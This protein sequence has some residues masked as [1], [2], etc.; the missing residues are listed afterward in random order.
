MTHEQT[1]HDPAVYQM[2]TGYRHVSTAGGLKVE[3]DDVPHMAAALQRV[4]GSPTVMPKAIETPETMQMNGRV[5]PG[6]SGGFLGTSYDPLRVEVTSDLQV[7][8]PEF[9]LVAE[10]DPARF[11][12]REQLLS[13]DQ[14]GLARLEATDVVRRY[15]GLRRQALEILRAGQVS[16]AFDLRQEPPATRERYGLYRHGQATLLA[17]RLVEAGARFVTVYWGHEDQD[18]ADGKGPRPANNPWDTH[19]NH[20]PLVKDSLLPRADQTLAA[21]LDDLDQRGL[22]DETLVVWMGDF[23][24]TPRISSPWAS[25]DHWPFAFSLLMA[26]GGVRRGFVYG[27]T[28]RHA[29]HVTSDP[30]T[31]ADLTATIFSALGV[32]P[33]TTVR[34]RRGERHPIS[35]GR[36]VKSLFA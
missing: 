9:R 20:F 28:D 5:L 30:V 18:W 36:V 16:E 32:A 22:L 12:Q 23:G 13:T 8:E 15:E 2:L 26:G 3:P 24:R 27:A 1:V 6:Q 35:T 4:D 19:R 21:L 14:L 34:N 31:P 29:A 25:R 11:Q 33:H 17:R 7:R 10:I